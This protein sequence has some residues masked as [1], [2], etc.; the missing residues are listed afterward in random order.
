MI[1][2]DTH[3]I[4]WLLGDPGKL[5]GVATRAILQSEAEGSGLG[6]STVS[7]YEISRGVIRGR[8]KFDISLESFL[9]LLEARFVVFPV[10]NEAAKLGAELPE[11]FPG[12]PCDRFITG[13]ALS[14]NLP[15]VTM[16][17]RIR[18]SRVVKTIW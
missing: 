6:I 18:T 16:D 4:L 2:L 13:T 8:L 15:L 3:V 10:S 14:L 11:S 7:L 5:S 1:L 9:E 17:S 12:D